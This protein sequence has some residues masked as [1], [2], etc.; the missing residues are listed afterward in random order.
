[1]GR[2][3]HVSASVRMWL[4]VRDASG[5]LWV[6]WDAVP[7]QLGKGRACGYGQVGLS[8]CQVW[9]V[10]LGLLQFRAEPAVGRRCSGSNLRQV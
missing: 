5:M 7:P 9:A 8:V 10:D 1:M 6:F 3:V 4:G 2:G